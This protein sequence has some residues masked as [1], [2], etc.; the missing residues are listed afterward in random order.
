MKALGILALLP[1]LVGSAWAI[2]PPP[3]S[4]CKEDSYLVLVNHNGRSSKLDLLRALDTMGRPTRP[5]KMDG[6]LSGG[7][8]PIFVVSFQKV[9]DDQAHDR[10]VWLGTLRELATIPGVVVECNTAAKPSE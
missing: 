2:N 3:G 1:A 6:I 9:S 4:S 7:G 10:A 8:S 5:M